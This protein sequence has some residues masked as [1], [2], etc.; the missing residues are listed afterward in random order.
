MCDIRERAAPKWSRMDR[1]LAGVGPESIG[2]IASTGR[3]DREWGRLRSEAGQSAARVSRATCTRRWPSCSSSDAIVDS[4]QRRSRLGVD[5]RGQPRSVTRGLSGHLQQPLPGIEFLS[6][7]FGARSVALQ[8][9][10][11]QI[12]AARRALGGGGTERA[13]RSE[14]LATH[15]TPAR[16][17]SGRGSKC[18]EPLSSGLGA[19][20]GSSDA[21]FDG[22]RG[23]SK[24]AG[25]I[26][27]SPRRALEPSDP[28]FDPVRRASERIGPQFGS[29]A[30]LIWPSGG[31]I[32]GRVRRQR[33]MP[34]L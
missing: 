14:A 34:T 5:G 4:R 10:S 13:T 19:G 8:T 11:T 29:L 26:G 17:G 27:V 1:A 21:N 6:T 22:P 30:E 33:S 25:A 9:R 18:V 31:E 16:G 3:G 28:N 32:E 7:Q 15:R 24:V 23:L 20:L 12:R 2:S